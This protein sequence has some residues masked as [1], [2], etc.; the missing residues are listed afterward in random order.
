MY[1]IMDKAQE[2]QVTLHNST[3]SIFNGVKPGGR[4]TVSEELSH[5]YVANG[6]S[7]VDAEGN[8]KDEINQTPAQLKGD[9]KVYTKKDLTDLLDEAKVDY[10]KKANHAT[11]LELAEANGLLDDG[12]DLTL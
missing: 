4:I 9:Q 7:Y 6:F 5:G 12:N 8:V 11:L 2:V 3:K 10:P 1:S